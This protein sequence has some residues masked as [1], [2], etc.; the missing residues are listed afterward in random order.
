MK[1]QLF[2]ENWKFRR[3]NEE[4]TINV[5]L[6]H[7]AMFHEARTADAPAG[8]AEHLWTMNGMMK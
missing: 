5:T 6:P 2:N 7:D 8:D 3:L 1:K 4:E